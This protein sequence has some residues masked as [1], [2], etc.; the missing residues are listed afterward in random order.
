MSSNNSKSKISFLNKGLCP[1]TINHN[2]QEWEIT[3]YKLKNNQDKVKL[4][5]EHSI[6]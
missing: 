3:K 6:P 5:R 4:Y 2:H 1:D